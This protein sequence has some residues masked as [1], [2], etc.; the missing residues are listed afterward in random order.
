MSLRACLGTRKPT[1]SP[2]PPK[3]KKRFK[4]LLCLPLHLDLNNCIPS[5]IPMSEF[6]KVSLPTIPC[7][8]SLDLTELVLRLV[9]RWILKVMK[10]SVPSCLLQHCYRL[11]LSILSFLAAT[12]NCPGF[13]SS[14]SILASEGTNHWIVPPSTS[15]ISTS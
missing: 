7:Q 3:T 12:N 6:K 14:G 15:P 5:W 2:S 1:S 8:S 9:T 13:T 4:N 11:L 10:S